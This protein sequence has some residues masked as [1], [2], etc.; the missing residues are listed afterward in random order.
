M[1]Y[2]FA[3]SLRAGSGR[4][5]SS[6]L[7]LLASCIPLLCVQ[8]KTPD[9]GQRNCPKHVELYSKN[10]FEELVHLVGFIIRVFHDARSPE[11]QIISLISSLMVNT[12]PR[13]LYLRGRDSVPIVYESRWVTPV[14]KFAEIPAPLRNQLRIVQPVASRYAYCVVTVH[15]LNTIISQ[16]F[17]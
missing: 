1:S 12:T 9:D 15:L 11:R 13:P 4:N 17:L 14:W 10:K 2:R 16:I 7:I 5:C 8:W 3:G 6:V